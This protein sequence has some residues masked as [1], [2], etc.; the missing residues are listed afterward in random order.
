MKVLFSAVAGLWLGAVIGF[1]GLAEGFT[2][3]YFIAV[4]LF[5]PFAVTA[6]IAFGLAACEIYR[7]E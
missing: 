1:I 2:V 4:L 5:A 7:S 6:L 3:A